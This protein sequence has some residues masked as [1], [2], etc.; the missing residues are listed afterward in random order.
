MTRETGS[1][2]GA[3]ACDSSIAYLVLIIC[4]APMSHSLSISPFDCH[5]V[6]SQGLLGPFPRLH[7]ICIVQAGSDHAIVMI[8]SAVLPLYLHPLSTHFIQSSCFLFRK[9]PTF[10]PKA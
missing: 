8:S 6:T 3:Y 2:S 9:C 7:A 5:P 10:N 1:S 4:I